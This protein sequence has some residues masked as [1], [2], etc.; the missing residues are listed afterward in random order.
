MLFWCYHGDLMS[1]SDFT[2]T[3]SW[4]LS[5]GSK[6]DYLFCYCPLVS[7]LFE[8]GRIN[9]IIDFWLFLEQFCLLITSHFLLGTFTANLLF[10]YLPCTFVILFRTLSFTFVK[11]LPMVYKEV[12]SANIF[13]KASLIFWLISFYIHDVS[14]ILYNMQF[15]SHI[16]LKEYKG[17]YLNFE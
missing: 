6:H 3:V 11:L 4:Q 8:V 13:M 7:I 14:M 5:T 9:V 15:V 16:I 2:I 1:Q 10:K 17:M 12:S